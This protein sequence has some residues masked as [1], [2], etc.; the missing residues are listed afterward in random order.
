MNDLQQ[1]KISISG[2]TNEDLFKMVNEDIVDYGKE[3]ISL[4]YDELERRGLVPADEKP[5]IVS[6]MGCLLAVIVLIVELVLT[7]QRFFVSK[8]FLSWPRAFALA[9]FVALLADKTK[10]HSNFRRHLLG[11]AGLVLLG[12]LALWDLPNLL[13]QRIPVALAF[14]IPAALFAA[15]LFWFYEFYLPRSR[16]KTEEDKH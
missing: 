13:R 15:F 12:S 8:E 11:S 5:P 16:H 6:S 14:G 7:E 1:R 9:A 2:L 4:A 3:E 10:F